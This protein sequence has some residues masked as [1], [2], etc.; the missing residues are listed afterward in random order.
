[1]EGFAFLIKTTIHGVGSRGGL[2]NVLMGGV[3]VG[4]EGYLLKGPREYLVLGYG[5]AH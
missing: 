1:M 2:T 4:I 5:C 3:G